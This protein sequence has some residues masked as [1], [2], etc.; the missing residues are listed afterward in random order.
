MLK[1]NDETF[2]SGE[3][4]FKPELL[5]NS[6]SSELSLHQ[7]VAE[8]LKKVSF[9]VRRDAC[10]NLCLSGGTMDIR[11]MD[12]RLENE[13]KSALPSSHLV[14]I[15]EAQKTRQLVPWTG[16]CIASKLSTFQNYWI[17]KDTYEEYGS[18]ALAVRKCF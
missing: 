18:S 5:K 11:N 16:G 6:K 9:D 12:K 2:K 14:E 8:S 10:E 7:L 15:L 13:I 1:L 17:D 4:L 3:V